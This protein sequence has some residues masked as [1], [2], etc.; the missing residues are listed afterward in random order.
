M[1]LPL[2]SL[3]F[4]IASAGLSLLALAPSDRT[5]AQDGAAATASDGDVAPPTEPRRRHAVSLIGTPKYPADFTHFDYVNPNAPKGGT[6]RLGAF[7][8]FDN[9][10]IFTFKGQT[11]SGIGLIYDTLLADSLEEPS[12]AYGLLAEWI[13]Y[14]DDFSSATFKLRDNARWHDGRPVTV[15]DVIFSLEAFKK[16]DPFYKFYYHNITHAK[17][18]APRQ[19]T[20]YF[21]VKN[22]RELP[23]IVGQLPV[24]PKHFWTG[25]NAKGELRDPSKTS[26][27]APLGSGPYRIKRM[28]PGKTVVYERVRD[29]WAKDLPVR[30]GHYNFDEIRFDY[31]RD[32]QV[33]FEAFKGQNLD[34]I[35]ENNSKRWATSYNFPAVRRGEVIVRKI[36]LLRSAGMQGFAFN[37]RRDKFK[38]ARVRRAFNLAFDFEW[39]NKNL[40]Y[41]QYT[42]TDSYFENTELACHHLPTGRELEFLNEVRDLVP[43]EVFT[44]PYKNPFNKTPHDL[45]KNIR[46]A[47]RLLADAGWVIRDNKLTN[48]TTGEVMRVEFLLVQKAFERIVLPFIRNLSKLGVVATVRVVDSAQYKRRIDSFDFDIVVNSFSQSHSPGNEQR[49]FWASTAADRKGSRNII[50]IKNPAVDKLID[51]IIFAENRADLVAATRALDRVLLWNHYVVPNW[52][53][54]YARVAYWNKFHAPKTMPK[55]DVGFTSVWWWD[56]A[57]A[58]RLKTAPPKAQQAANEAPPPGPSDDDAS[59]S[60]FSRLL[61][62]IKGIF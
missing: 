6:A 1:G 38:D 15:E 11:V 2:P 50:G 16:A 27:E 39:A 61:Q 18:T 49:D 48:T 3:A 23:Q 4:L 37:I 56:D 32:Q 58:A 20:F 28:N 55:L 26:M 24:L 31:Y 53:V 62:S 17:K 14:P 21:N 33:I 19:V 40:F 54:P 41:G 36:P 35:T 44:T 46:R 34:F 5:H 60:W 13:S 9:T 12:T 29:Y 22:N 42:R 59:G 25:K 47:I 51:K 8:S 10:N 45:R 30:R 43:P 7:G 52:H 57:A